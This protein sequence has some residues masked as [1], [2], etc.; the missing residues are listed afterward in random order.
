M[1]KFVPTKFE[2]SD[3]LRSWIESDPWHSFKDEV[4][5]WITGAYLTFKL[6]DEEG[7]VLF[8]R[9]DRDK[10]TLLRLH[11][12]FA[13]IMEVSEARV[14]MAIIKGIS[15]FIPHAITNGVTGIITES[16]STKLVAFLQKHLN[17]KPV[18]GNDFLLTFDEGK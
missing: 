14:A 10:G 6:V 12:Q 1:I 13:P 4:T 7:I 3:L 18:E 11:T 8:V 15:S 16:V 2:D 9:L 5:W 17:F